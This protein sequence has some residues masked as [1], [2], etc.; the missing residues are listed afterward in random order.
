MKFDVTLKDLS[1]EEVQHVLDSI[2]GRIPAATT[3]SFTR[4]EELTSDANVDQTTAGSLP[5]ISGQIDAEGLPWDERI[6][7]GSKKQTAKG[8]WARRK[9]VEDN[10]FNQVVAE[11]R[12][13]GNGGATPMQPGNMGT[14][15]HIPPAPVTPVG[16]YTVPSYNEAP[17]AAPVVLAAPMPPMP[18]MPTNPVGGTGDLPAFLHRPAAT[19]PAPPSAPTIN[20]LFN[21]VQNLFQT[22][23]ADV[24]YVNSLT[25]RLSQRFGVQ[26]MSINDISNRPDM[27]SDAFALLAADGK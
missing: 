25:S 18:P 12:N 27:I 9:N 19:P 20:D 22:G 5:E 8:V 15:V 17:L 11:L 21:K 10:F 7:S 16:G 2:R 26:V 24:A 6:H 14:A 1:A 4:S 13:R 23:K 3:Q